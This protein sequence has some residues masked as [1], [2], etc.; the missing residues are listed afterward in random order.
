MIPRLDSSES[1]AETLAALEDRQHGWRT[2][3][4]EPLSPG[5]VSPNNAIA[6]S[7]LPV[8]RTVSGS[9]Y[10]ISLSRD[11]FYTNAVPNQEDPERSSFVMKGHI[12]THSIDEK[13]LKLPFGEAAL[14]SFAVDYE[15]DAFLWASS[16]PP[17]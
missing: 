3:N 7:D 12:P 9:V 11:Y 14:Y 5:V 10:N 2:L 15:H 16:A 8:T 6:D 4:F 1:F 17:R 13:W